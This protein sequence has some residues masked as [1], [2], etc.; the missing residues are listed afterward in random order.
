MAEWS[1]LISAQ[2]RDIR[3]TGAITFDTDTSVAIT[4]E[5]ITSFTISEGAD[6][7]LMPGDVLCAECALEL[8]N[9]I[10]QW[11]SGG[12]LL[13]AHDLI[14]ATVRL[15]LGVADGETIVRRDLGTFIITGAVRAAAE[16][17]VRITAS[18]SIATELQGA[19]V[20]RLAYP[21][22]LSALWSHAISQT[23]YIHSGAIPN[24]AARIEAAPE[25]GDCSLR[26]ALG[27]IAA[28][29][30][31]FVRIGR[32]GRLNLQPLW[33]DSIYVIGA[34]AYMRMD[35]GS[36]H[37]GPVDALI[38]GDITYYCTPQRTSVW[39]ISIGGNPLLEN[40]ALAQGAADAIAGCRYRGLDI[41]W[42]GDPELTIGSRI[43]VTDAAGDRY[44]GLATGQK[45][46]YSNGFSASLSCAVP[47]TS[48]AGVPRIITPEGGINASMLVGA[49]NGQLISARSIAADKLAAS[50]VTAEKIAASA[51]TANKL[52]ANAV[53]AQAISAVAA[54][55]GALTADDIQS[56]SMAAAL[57]AFQVITAGT[58]T[59]DAATIRHLISTALHVENSV[60]GDAFIRNLR[61]AYAQIVSAT[62][63]ELCIRASDG[64]YYLLDVG[65][66]GTVTAAQTSVTGAEAA[67]GHTGGGKT[68]LDTDITAANLSTA[69]IY[70]TYALVNRIDAARIDVD[71]L[72]ARQAFIDQLNTMDIRSNSYIRMMVGGLVSDDE[73]RR[74]V[75]TDAQGLHIGDNQTDNDILIDSGSVNVRIGGKT[76]TRMGA[77]YQRMG[78]YVI[79]RTADGGM[80]FRPEVN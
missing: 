32:D 80:T 12:S 33:T 42:R 50:S 62:I 78:G 8:A 9:E 77:N 75:R 66:D 71:A 37:Y 64:N 68:I 2:A 79:R 7:A 6:G 41:A 67:Q 60:G 38:V 40:A 23:R 34:D 47:N 15:A 17:K 16:A 19:F 48:D 31:C 70:A 21:A 5:H 61:V 53:D 56:D 54:R 30:G 51:V 43:R 69:N 55:I 52:A 24:G 26:T 59:F 1:R 73:F 72:M 4:G 25:W 65:T 45:L 63:G 29:A 20:D 44:D 39:P 28:A 35:A 74:Y 76:F 10:G 18:D 58:A 46:T 14:G 13:G 22:T 36:D 3:V 49:V 57:A 27:M 11:N